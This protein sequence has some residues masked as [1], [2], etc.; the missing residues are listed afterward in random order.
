MTVDAEKNMVELRRETTGERHY[1]TNIPKRGAYYSPSREFAVRQAK[2]A[3]KHAFPRGATTAGIV[4]KIR[5]CGRE[6]GD[7]TL[8][9]GKIFKI[10]Q[11]G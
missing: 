1:R 11:R 2:L 9:G 7:F 5:G 4:L 8:K 10:K 6:N 3:A